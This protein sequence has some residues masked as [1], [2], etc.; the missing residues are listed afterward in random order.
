MQYTVNY[1]KKNNGIQI[2]V[3]YKD[4]NGKWRQ[5]CKQG[6]VKKSLAKIAAETIIEDLKKD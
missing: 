5:K 3:Q 6:F 4:K 2:I 1:R